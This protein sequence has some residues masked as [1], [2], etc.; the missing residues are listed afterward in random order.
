MGTRA[1]IWVTMILLAY[2]FLSIG[3]SACSF[4]AGEGPSV[5]NVAVLTRLLHET[6]LLVAA[7]F[8]EVQLIK[9]GGY[10]LVALPMACALAF[11]WIHTI[12][13]SP[14]KT[15]TAGVGYV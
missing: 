5:H 14:R 1:R 11:V 13:L 2:P 15:E 8:S 9:Y 12:K 3:A 4:T 7:A 6:G 10:A